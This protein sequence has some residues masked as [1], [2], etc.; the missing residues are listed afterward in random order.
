MRRS[1]D[2]EIGEV[3]VTDLNDLLP[4]QEYKIWIVARTQAAKGTKSEVQTTRTFP[5]VNLPRVTGMEPRK[6]LISWTSPADIGLKAHQLEYYPKEHFQN[7]T[8]YVPDTVVQTQPNQTYSYELANLLPGTD[9]E[10]RVRAVFETPGGI[11]TPYVWPPKGRAGDEVCDAMGIRI[12]YSRH[13][14][15]R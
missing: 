14:S 12:K 6:L 5:Q 7:S 9:Y 8:R 2:A 4:N 3:L 15:M 1:R 10:V 13:P 11:E